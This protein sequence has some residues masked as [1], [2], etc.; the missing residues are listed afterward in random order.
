MITPSRSE[1]TPDGAASEQDPRRDAARDLEGAFSLLF[2]QLRRSYAQAA[3]T[4]SSGLLPG[5]FKV[6]T[7]IDKIGPVS[8]STLAERMDVDKGGISRAVTELEN[9]GLIERE[10]DP[11]DARVRLI[12][13]TP[14]GNERLQIVRYPFVDRLEQATAEWTVE[15]MERLSTLVQALAATIITPQEDDA[16]PDAP[17]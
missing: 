2:T 14:F 6:F 10:L 17:H 3:D 16:A 5:T 1:A 9:L 11:C 4:V 7:V 12:S 8:A 13:V 15:S